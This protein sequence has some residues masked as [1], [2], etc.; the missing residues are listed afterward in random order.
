MTGTCSQEIPRRA[1]RIGVGTG[2]QMKESAAPSAGGHESNKR[3]VDAAVA[4]FH[5]G[6]R[7]ADR[8]YKGGLTGI[9]TYHG[10]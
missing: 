2:A 9:P 1:E 6:T 8:R 10:D 4:K 7:K 3:W 5:R